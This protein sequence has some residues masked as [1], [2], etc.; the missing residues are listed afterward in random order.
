MISAFFGAI[1]EAIYD[2][3]HP[4]PIGGAVGARS[5]AWNRTRNDYIQSS[6]E[7]VACGRDQPLEVHH[8]L[9]FH[10]YPSL[11]LIPENLIT[12]CKDCHF[13]FGHL[14]DWT[15]WNNTVVADAAEFRKRRDSRP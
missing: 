9:P 8:I 12:L 13:T 14:R 15:S 6:P 10:V 5:P 4:E 11:E 2:W 7:C 1:C 3:F